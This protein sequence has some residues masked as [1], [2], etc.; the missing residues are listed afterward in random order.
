V[1]LEAVAD[2]DLWIWHSF[3]AMVG[4]H[5]DINVPQCSPMFSKLVEGH[6]HHA[7]TRSMAI[8]IPKAAIKPMVSIQHGWHL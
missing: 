7:I 4:S 1:V 3:F 5:N 6:L 8:N 2:Y